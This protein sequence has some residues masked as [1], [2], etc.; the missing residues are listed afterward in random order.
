MYIRI[1]WETFVLSYLS[2]YFIFV[3]L[4]Q[5]PRILDIF[6]DLRRS[7]EMT[8]IEFWGSKFASPFLGSSSK[9]YGIRM[10]RTSYV[11][12]ALKSPKKRNKKKFEQKN[13]IFFKHCCQLS[14]P[15]KIFNILLSL[16]SFSV[17]SLQ[18]HFAIENN[19]K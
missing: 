19:K 6:H 8:N 15:K 12:L 18:T 1:F 16:N 9:P 10:I 14:L 11:I 3:K 7:R 4:K 13:T 17:I 2:I 5:R